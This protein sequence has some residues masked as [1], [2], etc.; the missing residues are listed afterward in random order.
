MNLM[1]K[2]LNTERLMWCHLLLE[3]YGPELWYIKGE[4]NIVADSLSCLEITSNE[5]YEQMSFED[6]CHL[7]TADEEDFPAECPFSYAKILHKQNKD[8]DSQ[9]S[10]SKILKGMWQNK[11]CSLESPSSQSQE[12]VRLSYLTS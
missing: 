7:Y 6:I 9:R 8:Q 4:H 1:C 11:E 5:L 10:D 2:M 12:K 3:E